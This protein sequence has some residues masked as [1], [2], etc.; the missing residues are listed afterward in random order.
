MNE[1]MNL[2]FEGTPVRVITADDGTPRWALADVC[3]ACGI[4]NSRMAPKPTNKNTSVV[5]ME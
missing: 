2:E 5:K 4:G 3:T 1:L